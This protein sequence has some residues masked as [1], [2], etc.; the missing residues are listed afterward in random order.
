MGLRNRYLLCSGADSSPVF[1]VSLKRI[2]ELTYRDLFWLFFGAILGCHVVKVVDKLFTYFIE[3][4]QLMIDLHKW[5]DP[6][7]KETVIGFE[8]EWAVA[9]HEPLTDDSLDPTTQ[10][11]YLPTPSVPALVKQP[12]NLPLNDD[13]R[14]QVPI[15]GCGGSRES[16][17]SVS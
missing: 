8:F 16:S 1:A 13:R 9:S 2:S 5:T 14:N 6:Y 3:T 17:G 10:R 12:I 7:T 11:R 15:Q 4:G